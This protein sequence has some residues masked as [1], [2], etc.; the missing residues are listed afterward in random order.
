MPEN[1]NI[2]FAHFNRMQ[3]RIMDKD[4]QVTK[5]EFFAESIEEQVQYYNWMCRQCGELAY[6]I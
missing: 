1:S 5:K 4:S 2:D 3:K 6:L